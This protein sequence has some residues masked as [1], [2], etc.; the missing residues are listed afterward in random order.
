MSIVLTSDVRPDEAQRSSPA[1]R[2]GRSPR[3]PGAAPERSM[4]AISPG[5]QT[6]PSERSESIAGIRLASNEPGRRARRS[7]CVRA[8]RQRG[9]DLADVR[10]HIR[11]EAVSASPLVFIAFAI[12]MLPTG[13]RVVIVVSMTPERGH[14][15]DHR[16]GARTRSPRWRPGRRPASLWRAAPR[17][18]RPRRSS[19]PAGRRLSSRGHAAGGPGSEPTATICTRPRTMAIVG[20]LSRWIPRRRASSTTMPAPPGRHQRLREAQLTADVERE[21]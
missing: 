10:Q 9:L 7:S 19:R 21:L 2:T 6:M 4:P 18:R 1:P 14:Q 8:Q 16:S 5:I 17:L 15:R 3:R 11:A 20:S 13:T 12:S